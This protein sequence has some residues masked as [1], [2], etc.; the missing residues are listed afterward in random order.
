MT[1]A[2]CCTREI[3]TTLQINYLVVFFVFLSFFFPRA[4]PKAYG[5]S[6]ARDLIRA[7]ATS[8]RHSHSNTR[9]NPHLR[10]T[11]QLTATLDP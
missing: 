1:E 6:Q 4:A 7:I 2:L 8:P 10:P 3:G 9:S 5:G 11:P